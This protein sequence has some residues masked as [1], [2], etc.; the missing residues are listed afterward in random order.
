[1]PGSADETTRAI[2]A[3]L[4][5]EREP[6]PLGTLEGRLYG[7]LQEGELAEILCAVPMFVV[8]GEDW[9]LGRAV[10]LLSAGTETA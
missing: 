2:V 4:A 1:V 6:I 3:V 8:A 9:Q 5:R 10:T 7:R